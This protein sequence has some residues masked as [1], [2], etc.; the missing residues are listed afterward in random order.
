MIR[1]TVLVLAGWV[2]LP[3]IWWASSRPSAAAEG[4]PGAPGVLEQKRE[5]GKLL[6]A[7]RAARRDPDQRAAIVDEAIAK[8]SP[9]V[10]AISDE[11]GRQMRPQLARYSSL[12]YQQAGE[13]TKKQLRQV[14]PA[15]VAQL[16]QKVLG[17]Q[18]RP[19]F[20]KELIE[21]EGDPAMKRLEE[22]FVIGREK[23]LESSPSLQAER[24][25]LGELGALWEKC[26]AFLYRELPDDEN[27]PKEAP[28]FEKYL[29]GE[30]NMAAGLAAPMDA[31]TLQVLAANNR[32]SAQLDPEESRA[33]L[34][35]NL[36][37]NLLGLN[38]CLID[39]K[40]CA[41]ARDHSNDM[42]TL[43]FFAHESP[44]AG[45]KTPWDRAARFGTSASAENIA[46]GYPD[47]QAA[48]LGWFHSPGHHKN[49]LGNHTRVGLGRA[50]AYYTQMFGR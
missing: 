8:G 49:M 3:A 41:A 13:L 32:L 48:N 30:E 33:V 25:R 11:I 35:L 18:N 42:M 16:R 14:D 22:M 10:A 27:K 34:A 21:R 19:D 47:G 24:E 4:E 7:Y 5:V 26:A 43:K 45:K 40:L 17:L 2:L 1:T 36:M 9:F 44:V 39:L 37:R 50:G 28:S 29:A 46:M 12:F 31:A 20:S 23:V 15:E 6:G 38:A